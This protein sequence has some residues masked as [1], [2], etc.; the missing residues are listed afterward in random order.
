MR[1]T[2]GFTLIELLVVI[3][4]IALLIGILL[5][6]LNAARRT[7]RQ[8]Q[9]NTIVRGM[10]QALVTYSQGNKT[11]YPGVGRPDTNPEDGFVD[12]AQPLN[13]TEDPT[14]K[15][16]EGYDVEARYYLLLDGNYFTGDY[17]I[18]PVDS[19]TGWTSGRVF[20]SNYSYSMLKID[21]RDQTQAPGDEESDGRRREWQDTMNTQAVIM[22]DR[23][24]GPGVDAQN[25]NIQ[26]LSVHTS[27]EGQWKGSVVWNDNHV[28]F[29]SSHILETKYSGGE[30]VIDPI[31][32]EPND[33]LF[34]E[35]DD[36]S[37]PTPKLGFDAHMIHSEHDV[38]FQKP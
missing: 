8:M 20:S 16:G 35:D 25:T 6:A 22:S 23:N 37:V 9:S 32:D 29:E 11:K 19:K 12:N 27:K 5:P 1:R 36:S 21:D 4:I 34:N 30:P 13:S 18:S 33:N 7:A 26:V 10:H 17:P 31:T 3:S 38:D 14:G 28:S 24:T 2:K 15:S